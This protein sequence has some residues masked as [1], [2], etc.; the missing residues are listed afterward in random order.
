MAITKNS[1]IDLNG[2]EMILDADGDT[3][4]TA[5]TD[6]QIDFKTAGTDRV[7]INSTGDFLVRQTSADIYDT[8]SGSSVRQF[9]GNQFSAQN[10]TN[11]RVI[12][13]SASNKGLVG[14]ATVNA[15][16]KAIV[17]SY[18]AFESIDQTA[19]GED[20]VIAFYTSSGGGSGTEKMRV[21]NDGKVGIGTTSPDV[22]FEIADTNAYMHIDA[23]NHAAVFIDRASTSYHNNVFYQTADTTNWRL[24][25]M[26][27]DDIL[28]VRDE[29][30]DNSNVMVWKHGGNVGI[31]T[32]SPSGRLHITNTGGGS[33]AAN[34]MTVEGATANN[35]NYPAIEVKGGT[36]ANV[37]PA[38]GLTN[39]G[40]GT[41]ITAG[42]HTSNYNVRAAW[43]VNNGTLGGYTSSGTSY[44]L[45]F[46]VQQNGDT[47][48]ND[49]TISSL[50]DERVKTDIKDLTDGLEIVKQLR[51]VTFKYDDDSTDDEG[52]LLMASASDKI[53]YGFIAQEVE[54]VAPQYVETITRKIK[55]VEVD[56][57]KT[58]S[59]TRMIPMLFKAIQEQ[60]TQIEALQSEVN[61]LKGG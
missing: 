9:W 30:N 3:T 44:T 48:T 42:Y 49:G 16:S 24:G 47:A 27:A 31:G 28:Q 19:G 8:N 26:G 56:D 60:Q 2:N 40:L 45:T 33:T 10:N 13:G 29:V 39:G 22:T 46:Q 6:D 23:T 38:Y 17:N 43:S 50:S 36:L 59:A 41:W 61:T 21:T 12:I 35:S 37:Y 51:P 18:M 52:N 15:S 32:D 54:K 4:I 57:F 14:G 5:D 34:W 58:L 20:G 25:Q 1:Q 53:R 11:S 7:Q 55:N